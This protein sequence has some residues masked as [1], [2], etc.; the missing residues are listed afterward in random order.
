MIGAL[1]FR[2]NDK[3]LSIISR[4]VAIDN[5]MHLDIGFVL[6]FRG[7]TKSSRLT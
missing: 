2:A 4:D 7:C 1:H 6:R 5:L 3:T